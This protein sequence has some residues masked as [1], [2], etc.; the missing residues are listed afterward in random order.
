MMEV[1]RSETSPD[2]YICHMRLWVLSSHCIRNSGYS[3][4]RFKIEWRNE[5]NDL[6]GM[7]DEWMDAFMYGYARQTYTCIY[8]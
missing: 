3:R 1:E 6:D 5:I 8:E 2:V 7:M 4:P